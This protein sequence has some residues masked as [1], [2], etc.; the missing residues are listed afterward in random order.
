LPDLP[1]PFPEWYLIV[2]NGLW[3]IAGLIV[4]GGLFSGQSWGPPFARLSA[5]GISIWYWG[6]R[7]FLARSDFVHRAWPV[8]AAITL[9]IMA[10]L[11]WTLKRPTVQ[12]FFMENTS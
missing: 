5:I 2:K 10:W 7:L 1:L 8:A 6:D 4:T 9:L 3:S 12:D 11:F